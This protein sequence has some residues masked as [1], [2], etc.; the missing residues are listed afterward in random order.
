MSISSNYSL[1]NKCG[2][3]GF[4]RE[5]APLIEKLGEQS[6]SYYGLTG[7]RDILSLY[8]FPCFWNI[9][10]FTYLLNVLDCILPATSLNLQG[11]CWDTWQD[12]MLCPKHDTAY[13]RRN[14]HCTFS[15]ELCF[16]SFLFTWI[17]KGVLHSLKFEGWAFAYSLTE[18]EVQNSYSCG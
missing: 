14:L 3:C 5:G 17:L 13:Y 6:L 8:H 7:K 16:C 2:S 4:T 18:H 9:Q 15:G 12:V 11:S 10:Q 1:L